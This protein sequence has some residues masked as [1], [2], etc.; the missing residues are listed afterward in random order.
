MERL[1]VMKQLWCNY[2]LFCYRFYC[3]RI[4][5]LKF[6]YKHIFR[7]F[8]FQ[9]RNGIFIVYVCVSGVWCDVGSAIQHYISFF[10]YSFPFLGWIFFT[11]QFHRV[12][13]VSLCRTFRSSVHK[14]ILV[15]SIRRKLIRCF[16][17]FGISLWVKVYRNNNKHKHT[18]FV[19]QSSFFSCDS[20]LF[21]FIMAKQIALKLTVL[22]S[23]NFLW[24]FDCF[25]RPSAS[26]HSKFFLFVFFYAN[27]SLLLTTPQV[28][29]CVFFPLSWIGF[30]FSACERLSQFEVYHDAAIYSLIPNFTFVLWMAMLMRWQQINKFLWS[31]AIILKIINRGRFF[32]FL[33]FFLVCVYGCCWP[34]S[35]TTFVYAV[36]PAFSQDAINLRTVSKSFQ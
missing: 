5:V 36:Q 24:L 27:K 34:H 6:I 21:I 32:F 9:C 25:L 30:C 31:Q 17:R 20:I 12:C 28:T 33:F 8:H 13:M 29:F 3:F 16:R 18:G 19:T 14:F 1:V 35:A 10:Y 22:F 11:S 15:L 23:F 7:S 4:Y 2:F 26:V